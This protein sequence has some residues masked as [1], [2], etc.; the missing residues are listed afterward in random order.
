[1][2]VEVRFLPFTNLGI[3]ILWLIFGSFNFESRLM[4]HFTPFLVVLVLIGCQEVEPPTD[5]TGYETTYE[6]V[7]GSIHDVKG[8]VTFKERLDGF[9]TVVITLNGTSGEAKHPVHVHLGNLSTPQADVAAQLNPVVA[10][11]GKSET[12]LTTLAD[13]TP[14]AYADL[15]NLQACIKIHLSDSGP[16][17]DIVLAAGNI[18]QS[19]V[20]GI[21]SGKQDVAPCKGK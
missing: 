15:A 21:S 7:S 5:F 20:E 6:L 2:P 4:K 11:T 10:K 12:T 14:V 16:E 3:K 9:T 17:R 19:Y 1:M 13:E 18:G 8:I